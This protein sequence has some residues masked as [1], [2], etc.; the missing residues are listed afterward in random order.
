M[1]THWCTCLQFCAQKH[2]SCS[3][4]TEGVS[5]PTFF[6]FITS[7][8][9]QAVPKLVSDFQTLNHFFIHSHGPRGANSKVKQISVAPLTA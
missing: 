9:G 5:R 1:G 3:W 4:T 2:L 8:L 6:L 7:S